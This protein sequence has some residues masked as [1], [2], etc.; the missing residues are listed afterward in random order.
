MA[1]A[2]SATDAAYVVFLK[3]ISGDLIPIQI[4]GSDTG[5]T[6]KQELERREEIP[7]ASQR[8]RANGKPIEDDVELST[9]G[10]VAGAIVAFFVRLIPKP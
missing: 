3:P 10:V 2:V 8:L 9:Q 4:R 7:V 6:I 5:L 1:Q